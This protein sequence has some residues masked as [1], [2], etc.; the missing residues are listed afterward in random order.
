MIATSGAELSRFDAALPF[1]VTALLLTLGP[2]VELAIEYRLERELVRWAEEAN[3][4]VTQLDESMNPATHA[5]A[6]G[7]AIDAAQIVATVLAPAVGLMLLKP[8]LGSALA[9]LYLGSFLVAAAAFLGFTFLIPIDKYGA[10][11]LWIFSPVAVIGVA[12]NGA[13][14]VIAWLI[15]PP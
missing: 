12:L 15:G 7:W 1:I 13:A 2:F 6:A 8:D 3:V 5:R 4:D 14:A 11:K 10:W 9:L